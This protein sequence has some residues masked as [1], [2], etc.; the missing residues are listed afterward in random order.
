MVSRL[1]SFLRILYEYISTRR[2]HHREGAV[3]TG[4]NLS[5][6]NVVTVKGHVLT[7]SWTQSLCTF[8]T[9]KNTDF[10]YPNSY[11]YSLPLSYISLTVVEGHTG[12]VWE[13]SRIIFVC[14]CPHFSRY[15]MLSFC[16]GTFRH[17]QEVNIAILS[18]I[19]PVRICLNVLWY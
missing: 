15:L 19:Y 13:R 18:F 14:T 5:I 8:H 6:R 3:S 7:L 16:S 1:G 4:C 2:G 17:T 11:L 9:Y 10:N 12:Q